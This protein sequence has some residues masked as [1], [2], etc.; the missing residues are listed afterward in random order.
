[1]T[2]PTLP[3]GIIPAGA[4]HFYFDPERGADSTNPWRQ[5]GVN[6]KWYMFRS[7]E[8]QRVTGSNK[9]LFV[10]I[11][12]VLPGGR[13]DPM[14]WDGQGLPPVGS[15]QTLSPEG[16]TVRVLAHGMVRGEPVAVCQD[17]DMITLVVS[18]G[19]HSQAKIDREIGIE[20]LE[21]FVRKELMPDEYDS[22]FWARAFDKG[23]R[24]PEVM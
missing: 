2:K 5:L 23:L 20:R 10:D 9:H 16:R 7:G 13:L 18:A 6:A 4:T 3:A 24:A 19:F 14:I 12:D 17:G 1:M 8:W 21:L 22:A 15:E 11:N